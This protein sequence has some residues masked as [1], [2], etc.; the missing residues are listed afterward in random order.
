MAHT[1]NPN[2]QEPVAGEGLLEVQGQPGLHEFQT[3]QNYKIRL[4]DYKGVSFT[5]L[6]AVYKCQESFDYFHYLSTNNLGF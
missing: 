3:T 2:T 1:Y 5:V 6:Y 4:Y